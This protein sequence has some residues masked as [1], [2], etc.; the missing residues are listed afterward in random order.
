MKSLKKERDELSILR[1]MYAQRCEEYINQVSEKKKSLDKLMYEN[2]QLS[3]YLRITIEKKLELSKELEEYRILNE[4][5]HQI[6]KL[7]PSSRV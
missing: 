4:R 5:V 7:L 3:T 6:P 2:G 1:A